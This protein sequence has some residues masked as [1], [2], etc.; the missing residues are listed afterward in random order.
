MKSTQ[1]TSAI[2]YLNHRGGKFEAFFD[3]YIEYR[4]LHVRESSISQAYTTK[5]KYLNHWANMSVQDAFSLKNVADTYRMIAEKPCLCASW[6]NTIFGILRSMASF[7]FKTKSI[8]SEAFQDC[9]SI[10]DNVSEKKR[11]LKEKEIW[12]AK[13]EAK[14]LRAIEN[15]NHKI[16]FELFVAL[17][18][19]I[20]EFLGLT[21][22]CFDS[23]KGTIQI[24]QQL[25]HNSQKTFVLSPV[26][27]SSESYRICQLTS[28]QRKE[29]CSYKN[30]KPKNKGF[31]FCSP[32]NDQQPLSK[33]N[34]RYLFNKYIRL[35]GVKRIT[36]HSI[37]HARA[38]NLLMACHNMLE[39]VA[40]AKFMGH[41]PSMLMN[42]Y[43]HSQEKMMV[44][45][46]SRIK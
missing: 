25:L 7:A 14:F 1:H 10:L 5:R 12:N 46:I 15:E 16:M 24:K 37:R 17:G 19:R 22:D 38:S 44:T 43:G 2:C 39:V 20:S 6:K 23:K 4:S 36:P 13:E 18:A 41:S 29:L 9:V 32:I 42:T 3:S 40:V 31:I 34:F 35:S 11:G 33:A 28:A 8:S 21:W 27:K 45:I 30:K 26:L